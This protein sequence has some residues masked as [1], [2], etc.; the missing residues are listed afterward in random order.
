VVTIINQFKKNNKGSSYIGLFVSI[1][2]FFAIIGVI[3]QFRVYLST[4]EV[5]VKKHNVFLIGTNNKITEIYNDDNWDDLVD[6][7][8]IT[9]TFGEIE[10]TYENKGLTEFDTNLLKVTFLFHDKEK[11]YN[12]ER[13]IYYE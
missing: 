6:T 12:L 2:L 13:S 8:Y 1:I 10:V 9:T 11:I 5:K 7:E 3:G 4:H